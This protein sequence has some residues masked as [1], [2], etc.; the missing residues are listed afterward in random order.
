MHAKID[1]CKFKIPVVDDEESMLKLARNLSKE[2][3][4]A[5]S[6]M[7]DYLK[8]LSCSKKFATTDFEAPRIIATGI[9]CIVFFVVHCAI[10][11]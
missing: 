4:L 8:K 3:R 11:F 10:F 6:L 2:Q 5:F 1:G 9:I 7:I